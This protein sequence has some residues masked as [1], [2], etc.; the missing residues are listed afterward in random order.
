[1]TDRNVH[2]T[3]FGRTD[4]GTVRDLNEDGFVIVNLRKSPAVHSMLRPIELHVDDFGVLL[5]V[6]D[7]MGGARAG[8]VASA[9]TLHALRTELPAGVGGTAETALIAGVESA[10]RRVY[11]AAAIGTERHGMGATLTAVL[12][13]GGR[14]FVAQIGDSRAYALRGARLVRLTCDQSYVQVL[15][16]Q[17]ALT[18]EAAEKF[19]HKNI[20]L[21]AM[22]VGPTVVVALSRF[23]LRQGD[24]LLLCSD[25][26]S[27]E[28]TDEQIRQVLV[29][30]TSVDAGC[31]RLI[32]L[33]NLHGGAD[34]IT[35]VLAEVQGSGLP[36]LGEQVSLETVQTFEWQTPA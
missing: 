4:V 8:E 29:T 22:G 14:A 19:E 31:K 9:L 28:V 30:H 10:N 23:T 15:L 32:E 11:Q 1:M 20:I 26:L 5:A 27:N 12:V 35:V 21:Q 34:N 7:G 6:S 36:A 18:H 13:H 24:L 17:G 33:A 3:V 25:G 16:D 2:L